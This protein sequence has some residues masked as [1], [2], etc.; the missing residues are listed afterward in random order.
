M[1]PGNSQTLMAMAR[2]VKCVSARADAKRNETKNMKILISIS[3]EAISLE[4][5]NSSHETMYSRMSPSRHFRSLDLSTDVR[6][7]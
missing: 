3:P 5:V 6:P 4:A 7:W 1:D 2:H